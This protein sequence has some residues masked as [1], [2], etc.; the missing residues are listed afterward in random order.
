MAIQDSNAERRNLVVTAIAFIAYFY[1][2]GN[3]ANHAVTLQVVSINFSNTKFLAGMAW[4]AFIWFIYRYWLLNSGE[5]T[6]G[7]TSEFYALYKTIDVSKHLEKK[8][9]LKFLLNYEPA[10][11][12]SGYIVNG[13]KWEGCCVHVSYVNAVKVERDSKTNEFRTFSYASPTVLR[14]L[15]YKFT[16]ISDWLLAIRLTL[17]IFFKE[18]S[19]SDHFV[20]YIISA[21]ALFGPLYR[22]LA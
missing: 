15:E 19:F 6:K 22:W 5:F 13:I 4:A 10:E 17:R 2:D 16:G 21:I 9:K 12:E 20:P 1:G 14:A 18:R 11:G 3:F 7:F 8:T